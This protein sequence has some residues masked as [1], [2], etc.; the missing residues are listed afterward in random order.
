MLITS[1]SSVSCYRMIPGAPAPFVLIEHPDGSIATRWQRPGSIV[2]DGSSLREDQTIQPD[3]A[4]R[5]EAYF[6]GDAVDFADVPLP[7][8]A[9]AFTRRCWQVCRSIPSGHT[10]SY[11]ELAKRAGSP[12]AARAAGQAMRRNP[13]AVIVPCHRVVNFKGELHGYAGQ[14]DGRS[15]SLAVKRRLLELERN[16]SAAA[17]RAGSTAGAWRG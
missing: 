6:D 3:L 14:T 5:L 15:R 2:A 11:G 9:G 12:S 1:T 8:K 16:A 7:E 4:S 10:I 17:H 13:I